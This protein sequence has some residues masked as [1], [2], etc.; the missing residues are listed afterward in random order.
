MLFLVCTALM[1]VT[2][3]SDAQAINEQKIPSYNETE[4]TTG[5]DSQSDTAQDK[6]PTLKESWYKIITLRWKE[7]SKA[8]AW[9]IGAPI[10]SIA[11]LGLFYNYWPKNNTTNKNNHNPG[12][13]NPDDN[14]HKNPHIPANNDDLNDNQNKANNYMHDLPPL[15]QLDLAQI[16]NIAPPD[17][18]EIFIN[19][20][21]DIQRNIA[22]HMIANFLTKPKILAGHQAEI[23]GMAVSGDKLITTSGEGSVNVWNIDTGQLLHILEK[24]NSKK[25]NGFTKDYKLKING[26]YVTIG[27]SSV[28]DEFDPEN[29]INIWNTDTGELIHTFEAY[30]EI[31]SLAINQDKLAAG[32][33][34]PGNS[35]VMIWDVHSGTLLHE[36]KGHSNRIMNIALQ[37]NIL[38]TGSD[39][40]T[41]K[42]W[43]INDYQLLHSLEGHKWW[44]NVVAIHNNKIITG[45][46]DHTIKVWDKNNGQ[47]LYTFEEH[48][49]YINTLAI[50]NNKVISGSEDCTIKIWDINTGEVL[51]TLMGH[52][53]EIAKV[54]VND[55]TLLSTSSDS[56]RTWN[57]NTGQPLYTITH[58]K[59]NDWHSI[60]TFSRDT[61]ITNTS[62]IVKIWPLYGDLNKPEFYDPD[63]ALFWIR[64]NLL[65][66]QANL[67]SRINFINNKVTFFI[68][69]HAEFNTLRDTDDMY[70]WLT[71]PAHV[72]DYL[73][74]QLNIKLVQ[75][76]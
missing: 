65:P 31:K 57:I 40:N 9:N 43:D 7:L 62:N 29:I 30:D 37:D 76:S 73:M 66:L 17:R 45:S 50:C 18:N 42:I 46:M 16:I 8:D 21:D 61:I 72:R 15:P 60:A 75:I 13:I 47:L 27:S 24:P 69:T 3:F 41:A 33:G 53:K 64:H 71:F 22:L 12:H 32:V 54:L 44:V 56:T 20:I 4:Q 58:K 10:A 11:T 74:S 39:D 48:N 1:S 63:H 49:G 52:T 34:G 70:I 35:T 51:H 2:L 28:T 26:N 19:D 25:R 36:L 67:I 23:N 55:N 14:T 6:K 38:V 68:D 5:R 59:N